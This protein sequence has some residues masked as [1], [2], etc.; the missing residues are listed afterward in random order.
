[1]SGKAAELITVSIYEAGTMRVEREAY[2]NLI[3][4]VNGP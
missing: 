3:K 2:Q 1:M 4:E